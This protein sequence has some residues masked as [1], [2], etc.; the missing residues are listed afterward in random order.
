MKN[1][2]IAFDKFKDALT[3]H[4]ACQA[5]AEALAQAQPTWDIATSPLADG[6]DGFCDTLTRL[7]DGEFNQCF[8]SG[9]LRQQ[10][11]AS[12]GI[13]ETSK[14][15]PPAIDRLDL[16]PGLSKL[17]IIEFAQSSGIALVPTEQRS[18]WTTTSYGLGQTIA[19]AQANGA[20]AILIGLGGSAT[21]DLALGA[22]QALGYRL[23]DGESRPLDITAT[24]ERWRQVEKIQ[25]PEKP[26]PLPIRIA[27]DVENPLLGVNGATAIFGPQKGL[28]PSDF[29]RLESEMKRLATLLCEATQNEIQSMETPGSGAAGG[30]AFGLMLGLEGKLVQGAELVFDWSDLHAK[31][32]Q[33]DIVITGEGRFD[34][35]S[36]QGKGPGSLATLCLSQKKELLVL[37]GSLGDIP[38]QELNS[39]ARAISPADMPLPQALATT[40]ENIRATLLS[41]FSQ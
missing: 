32:A 9:P 12:Y 4:Q 22:L 40:E 2:L 26:I 19:D 24:P 28:L 41:E 36:L 5:A 8:V 1:A 25:A 15:A 23:L 13:V 6:G 14:I 30:A 38:D 18:P 31:L 21:N 10:T 35:S 3:A 16:P 17:A 27:C 34:A 20:E 33:A 29:E 37:A 7:C 11:C 39:R